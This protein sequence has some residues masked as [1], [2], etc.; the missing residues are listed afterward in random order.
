MAAP[1]IWDFGAFHSARD[2]G[3]IVRRFWQRENPVFDDMAYPALR[4][5]LS[6]PGGPHQS[7]AADITLL[8]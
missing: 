5:A 1:D 8:D 2:G 7:R 6:C 3:G 4:T